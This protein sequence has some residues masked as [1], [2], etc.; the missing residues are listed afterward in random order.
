MTD[1]VWAPH[2]RLSDCLMHQMFKCTMYVLFPPLSHI[3]LMVVVEVVE[4]LEMVEV[5]EV[6]LVVC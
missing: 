2:I 5:V 6:V 4:V 1:L 3:M